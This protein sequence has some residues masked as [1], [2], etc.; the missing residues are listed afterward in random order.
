MTEVERAKKG[1]PEAFIRLSDANRDTLLR[2]AHGFFR[3]TSRTSSSARCSARFPR[4]P[5]SSFSCSTE[6]GLPSRRLPPF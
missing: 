6:S 1:D 3:R 2:V 4:I 5:G